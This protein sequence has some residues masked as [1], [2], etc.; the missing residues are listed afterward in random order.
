MNFK[1]ITLAVTA[2]LLCGAAAVPAMAQPY[3]DRGY[4]D[5]AYADDAAYADE[6]RYD[7]RGSDRR[8][9][10][11]AYD[12]RSRYNDQYDSDRRDN[13]R[14]YYRNGRYDRRTYDRYDGRGYH[15]SCRDNRA[16]GTVFGAIAGAVIG[17]NLDDSGNRNDG[18]AIGAVLGGL[19]GN[20]IARSS[21]AC[22]AYGNY[23]SYNQTYEYRT[24]RSY[25]GRYRDYGNRGCRLAVA[26]TR[27]GRAEYVTVCPDRYGR[28][29]VRY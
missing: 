23:Y 17:S 18:T 7:D 27:Y 2:A 4:D 19:A 25:R 13:Y 24:P 11:R 1:P 10:D 9:D 26:E 22:D 5:G 12:D 14:D 20:S 16:A 21:N 28:Y 15:S 6:G 3:D 8:G 29:R